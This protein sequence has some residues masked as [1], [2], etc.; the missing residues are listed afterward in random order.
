MKQN[1]SREEAKK[2]L[3]YDPYF[4]KGNY[5][6]KIFQTLIALL[7][8]CGVIIP[9]LWILF[10]FVLPDQAGRNHVRV[11]Q[12]EKMTLVFLVIFLSLSFLF[13]VILY[14]SLTFWNNY[15]FKHFLQKSEQYDI[16][17]LKLRR[18]LI[19][20]VYDERFGSKEFRQNTPYYSVKEEQN[21]ETDFVKKL[22]E[23]GENND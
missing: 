6:S 22:Y 17:R 9:F 18:K 16:E 14:V 12:D 4:E 15:R 23:K 3:V 1:I 10:P 21:L 5:G 19:N 20:Q 13:L 7:S 11:Y 2:S 8:W